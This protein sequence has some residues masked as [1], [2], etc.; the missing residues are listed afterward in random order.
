MDNSIYTSLTR[1]SGLAR[2]M[3]SLA[4]NVANAGTHGFR[5]EGVIFSEY[6]ERVEDGPSLSKPQRRSRS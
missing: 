4:N 5:K 2:E 6:V 1:L 3:Q